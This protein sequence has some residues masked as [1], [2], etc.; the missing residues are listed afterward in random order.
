[1]LAR[2]PD[3]WLD[4]VCLRDEAGILPRRGSYALENVRILR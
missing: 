3:R 1:M 2:Q 4:H